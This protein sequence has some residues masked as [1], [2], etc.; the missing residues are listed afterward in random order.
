VS[1]PGTRFAAHKAAARSAAHLTR[2]GDI[3]RH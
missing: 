1:L 3:S 2:T